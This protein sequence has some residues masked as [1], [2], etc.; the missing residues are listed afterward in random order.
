MGSPD[1]DKRYTL[2]PAMLDLLAVQ[3][4]VTECALSDFSWAWV[5]QLS[6]FPYPAKS[7]S[8]ANAKR[9]KQRRAG[10]EC[11]GLLIR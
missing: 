9:Q 7:D 11:K 4:M 8:A 6:C 2:Y 1:G 5:Y 3:V 10:E